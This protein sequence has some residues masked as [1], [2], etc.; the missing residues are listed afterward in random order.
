MHKLWGQA[1]LVSC[2]QVS[3][4]GGAGAEFGA[5]YPRYAVWDPHKPWDRYQKDM[6]VLLD[7][8]LRSYTAN[9]LWR[10]YGPTHF[11]TDL[12]AFTGAP[13]PNPGP[14]SLWGRHLSDTALSHI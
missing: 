1:T 4:K 7:L 6:N 3:E 14:C 11:G 8:R 13:A 12:G 9:V 5:W 2:K 10:A